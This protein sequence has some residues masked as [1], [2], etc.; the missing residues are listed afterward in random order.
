MLTGVG[1][2]CA[3]SV[4]VVTDFNSS[5]ATGRHLLSH[6]NGVWPLSV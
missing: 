2:V 4:A 1:L 5:H 3:G 6:A